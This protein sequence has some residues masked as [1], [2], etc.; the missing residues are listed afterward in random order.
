MLKPQGQQFS[1]SLQVRIDQQEHVTHTKDPGPSRPCFWA[2][3]N[4]TLSKTL[5]WVLLKDTQISTE[6]LSNIHVF[7]CTESVESPRANNSLGCVCIWQVRVTR[8]FGPKIARTLSKTLQSVLKDFLRY[9]SFCVLKVLK[10]QGQQSSWPSSYKSTS[11]SGSCFLNPTTRTL[12]KTLQ[13]VLKDFPRYT[14]FLYTESVEAPG[15][16]ILLISSSTSHCAFKLSVKLSGIWSL[17]KA[18]S[19]F[20]NYPSLETFPKTPSRLLPSYYYYCYY[21]YYYYYYYYC[22]ATNTECRKNLRNTNAWKTFHNTHSVRTER[23]SHY[24]IAS[25]EKVAS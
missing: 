15:P 20:N 17:I 4:R 1:W 22:L 25:S 11:T 24:A 7:L 13:S 5:K 2:T 9:T 18:P 14:S 3:I 19:L 12:S 21:C 6:R 16:T 8:V 23:I 10:P